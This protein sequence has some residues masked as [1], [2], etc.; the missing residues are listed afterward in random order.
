MAAVDMVNGVYLA[1]YSQAAL[2]A[3]RWPEDCASFV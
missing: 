3:F 1:P 2:S